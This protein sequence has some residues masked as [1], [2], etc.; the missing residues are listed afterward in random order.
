MFT[1]RT[2]LATVFSAAVSGL[3]VRVEGGWVGI[4]PRA[5]PTRL[6]VE[7][8]LLIVQQWG[9]LGYVASAG[10]LLSSERL[11]A[12]LYSPFAASGGT[13]D[14]MLAALNEVLKTP[15]PELAARHQ[16]GELERR[17]V[18]ELRGAGHA[19][20]GRGA[21]PGGSRD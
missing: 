11:S 18:K 17:I 2:P 9:R 3:R 15:P 7:P 14:A 20:L 16:L 1:I 21:P 8:G 10:G 13:P 12:D 5:E 4:R 6:A 19:P